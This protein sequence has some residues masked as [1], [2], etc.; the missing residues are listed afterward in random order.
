[1]ITQGGTEARLIIGLL[2]FEVVIVSLCN[3]VILRHSDHWSFEVCD[4]VEVHK[5]RKS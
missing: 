3:I 5:E 1:M 2:F 4:L